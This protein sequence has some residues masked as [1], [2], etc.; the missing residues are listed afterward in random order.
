MLNT[1]VCT[2]VGAARSPV[3]FVEADCSRKMGLMSAATL[4][5]VHGINSSSATWSSL[6]ARM[7]NDVDLVDY[8]VAPPFDYEARLV[9]RF[10]KRRSPTQADVAVQ[11]ATHV[12]AHVP[13]DREVVFV[14]HSQGGLIV[15]RLIA[16]YLEAGRGEELARVRCVVLLSCPNSGSQTLAIAR[17]FMGAI[18]N[19]QD[20]TLSVFNT[21]IEHVRSVVLSRGVN[22]RSVSDT[23]CPITFRVYAGATDGIVPS[24]SAKGLFPGEIFGVLPG[25]HSSILDF[26][27][28]AGTGYLSVKAAIVMPS[29]PRTHV[30][31]DSRATSGILDR[32]HKPSL[33][34][35]G[36]L[37]PRGV[38]NQPPGLSLSTSGPQLV[39]DVAGGQ[40]EQ[41]FI[42]PLMRIRETTMEGRPLEIEI[43][44]NETANLWIQS[45]KNRDDSSE[46]PDAD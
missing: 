27:D 45:Y 24:V 46:R 40:I 17:R 13:N 31:G 33:A 10:G 23:T 7:E 12:K 8:T 11:L 6:K 36:E 38:A 14:A 35:T 37:S 42:T 28:P 22:A 25:D 9:R 44:D 32:T 20:K 30:P 3:Y 34:S 21:E 2:V 4:V 19:P 5:L 43:F 16:D 1:I 15:Q 18:L 39:S 41:R 29:R 26:S